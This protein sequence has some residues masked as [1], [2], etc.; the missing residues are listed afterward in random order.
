[1]YIMTLVER[2]NIDSKVYQSVFITCIIKCDL[3]FTRKCLNFDSKNTSTINNVYD[4]YLSQRQ[5]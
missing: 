3:F 2:K 4:A 5:N 1:V